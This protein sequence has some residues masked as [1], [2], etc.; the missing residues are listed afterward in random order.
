LHVVARR[1]TVSGMKQP[2]KTRVLNLRVTPE[3]KAALEKRAAA[4]RRTMSDYARLV[5]FGRKEKSRAK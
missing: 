2:T 1:S 5:L 3:E 4:D